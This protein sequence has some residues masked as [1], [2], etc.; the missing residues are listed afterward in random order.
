MFTVRATCHHLRVGRHAPGTVSGRVVAW[1]GR[2]RGRAGRRMFTASER[3]WRFRQVARPAAR[4]DG[5]AGRGSLQGRARNVAPRGPAGPG[6]RRRT[7]IR[8]VTVNMCLP[9]R[10]ARPAGPAGAAT[11]TPAV[12][13]GCGTLPWCRAQGDPEVMASGRDGERR[14]RFRGVPGP[15][16]GVGRPVTSPR[17]GTRARIVQGRC[18]PGRRPTPER[19]IWP[20]CVPRW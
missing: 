10:R 3:R 6:T 2:G 7:P 20:R 18:V 16:Q 13:P 11:L 4:R 5:L 1:P 15:R 12:T 9:G 8:S 17:D 14:R 19:V